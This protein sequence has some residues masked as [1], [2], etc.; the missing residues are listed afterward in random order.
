LMLVGQYYGFDIETTY[1]DLSDEHKK[2]VFTLKTLASERQEFE[3]QK[4][5]MLWQF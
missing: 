1:E 5:D 4:G 2:I 3:S